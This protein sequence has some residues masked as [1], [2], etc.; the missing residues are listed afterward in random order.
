MRDKYSSWFPWIIHLTHVLESGVSIM[1][2]RRTGPMARS[3]WDN[4][5]AWLNAKFSL[6]SQDARPRIC[7]RYGT[8]PRLGP[9]QTQRW[10]QLHPGSGTTDGPT[11]AECTASRMVPRAMKASSAVITAMALGVESW[12]DGS[13]PLAPKRWIGVEQSNMKHRIGDGNELERFSQNDMTLTKGFQ[14]LRRRQ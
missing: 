7:L 8:C 4:G 3:T 2:F 9:H 6:R 11:A 14:F 10:R 1:L 12:V 5:V 13:C